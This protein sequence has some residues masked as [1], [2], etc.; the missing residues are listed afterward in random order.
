[1][2]NVE[3]LREEIDDIDDKIVALFLRRNAAVEKIGE[4]K[5]NI[6]IPVEDKFREGAVIE[7]LTAALPPKDA[8][9]VRALYGKIFEISKSIENE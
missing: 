3:E 7:R 8:A 9:A 2:K 6:G 5:R 4:T 1:M